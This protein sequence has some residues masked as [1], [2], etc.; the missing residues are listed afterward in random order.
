MDS[1]CGEAPAVVFHGSCRLRQERKS[2]H[3][4]QLIMCW[5]E[6]N[7]IMLS[8]L[9]TAPDGQFPLRLEGQ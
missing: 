9:W 3:C 4:G 5:Q 1:S 2:S 7:A 8:P 6:A